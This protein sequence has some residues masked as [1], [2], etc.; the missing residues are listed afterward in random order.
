LQ[1]S[2][3]SRYLARLFHVLKTLKRASLEVFRTAGAFRVLER[4]PWRSHRLVVLAWVGVSQADEH[5]WDPGSYMRPEQFEQRLE[6]LNRHRCNVLPLDEAVERLYSQTLPERAVAL[7]F[8]DGGRDFY[9]AVWPLLKARGFPA[10][11]FLTTFYC[12]F[13]QPVFDIACSYLLWKGSRKL[14]RIEGAALGLDQ[15]LDL[16]T[17]RSRERAFDVIIALARGWRLDAEGKDH[18]L[19]RLAEVVGADY[20]RVRR[21]RLLHLLDAGEVRRLAADGVDF[22]LHTHRHRAPLDRQ[23]FLREIAE[24]RARLL[25]LTGAAPEFFAYPYGSFRHEFLA[26]L[27][28]A[29]VRFAA[30]CRPG[31]ATPDTHPLLLPRFFDHG[32][33]SPVEFESCISGAA[34]WLPG[35]RNRAGLPLGISRVHASHGL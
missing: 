9:T 12:D 16:R 31:P 35:G 17:P 10:T 14:D 32:N 33:L 5:E 30:T 3:H 8:D 1:Y 20:D 24:N 23:R 28:E 11:V 19:E 27:P 4:T 13:N 6:I 22:Q 21:N 25:D 7:T 2:R 34:S 18:L 15:T 26:W 29:G